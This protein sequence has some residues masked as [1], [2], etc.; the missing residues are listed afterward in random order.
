MSPQK[1][2]RV[3]KALADKAV[4]A[5]LAGEDVTGH[6][7]PQCDKVVKLYR[8]FLIHRGVAFSDEAVLNII[9]KPNA[10][11]T[12][13]F[14]LN[15]LGNYDVVTVDGH[16]ASICENGITRVSITETKQPSGKEYD[17]YAAE[18]V[19]AAKVIGIT[20]AQL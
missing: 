20:P 5:V 17:R 6:Y 4:H 7:G 13:N 10:K 16:A 18:Y 11:K 12:R 3:N 2:W 14:Y 1:E 8:Y 15:I 9:S 19:E